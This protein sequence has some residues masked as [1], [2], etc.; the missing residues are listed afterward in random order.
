MV[1]D[2]I[3]AVYRSADPVHP[4]HWLSHT[5]ELVDKGDL[6]ARVSLT[7]YNHVMAA[8]AEC[9]HLSERRRAKADRWATRS[10]LL[11]HKRVARLVENGTRQPTWY[12]VN[13]SGMDRKTPIVLSHV[14]EAIHATAPRPSGGMD[15]VESITDSENSGAH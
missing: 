9:R 14:W 1:W 11:F 4:K 5:T 6:H 3:R 7:N 13:V 10:T 12:Q 8:A 2:A 15:S